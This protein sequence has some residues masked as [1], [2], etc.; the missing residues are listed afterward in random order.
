[1]SSK[2][3]LS[4]ESRVSE[5]TVGELVEA[6][7]EQLAPLLT[8]QLPRPPRP[9]RPRRRPVR[10]ALRTTTADGAGDPTEL[11]RAK[12]QAALARMGFLPTK[13]MGR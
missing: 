6:L 13:P 12:A 2:R 11:D 9:A 8:N 3:S 1:M 7:I 10:P 4:S 5:L